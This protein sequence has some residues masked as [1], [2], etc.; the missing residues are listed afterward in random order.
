MEKLKHL[1]RLWEDGGELV[2]PTF[3]Q[4]IKTMMIACHG[5]AN[6]QRFQ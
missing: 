5:L 6:S 1:W 3:I 4:K 2:F